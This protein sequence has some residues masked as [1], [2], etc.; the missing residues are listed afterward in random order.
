VADVFIS[1]ARADHDR[2]RPMVE[3]LSSLGYSVFEKNAAT[4]EA[5]IDGARA[6]LVA[7]SG[8]GRNSTWVCAEA[9][10]ALDAGKLLQVRLDGSP[11]PPPFDAL[12]STDISNERAEWGPLEATLARLVREGAPMR[13]KIPM[14]GPLATANAAGAPKLITFALATSLVA[15]AGALTAARN[16]VMSPDQLQLALTGMIGV[17]GAGAALCI[18]RLVTIARAGG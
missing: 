11:P 4:A 2:V 16:G 15:Y 8:D 9:S 18:H 10:R 17:A 13:A 1:C 3:R 6:V 14:V 5:E 7:W 12:D